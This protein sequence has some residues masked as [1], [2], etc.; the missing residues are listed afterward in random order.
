VVSESET[1]LEEFATGARNLAQTGALF[2][3]LAG[4]EPLLRRDLVE[5]VRE[6][7]RFHF[8]FITTNGWLVTREN[9]K[10]LFEAGLWGASVSLDYADAEKHDARRGVKGAFERAVNA[11]GILSEARIKGHQRV[12]LQAVLLDDNL[13]EMPRL[14]QLARERRANFMVQPY[15]TLKTGDRRFV[16]R[17][18]V[19]K[20]LLALKRR[21]PNF[22]SNPLFI[23]A[24]DRSLS[25]GVPGCRCGVSFFNID[26]FGRVA[27]CVEDRRHPVGSVRTDDAKVL[28]KRLRERYR[29]NTCTKCWYNCRGEVEVLYSLR[30][31]VRTIPNYVAGLAGTRRK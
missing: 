25:E 24:F 20:R 17:R 31:L 10:A 9:A 19:S 6:V 12:N 14:A 8:T 2:I 13:D 30:G 28:L 22:L 4:G 5:I 27:K 7:S 23:G 18:S 15:C 21:Y 16:S 11:L 1:T 29:S 3:N 26:Q